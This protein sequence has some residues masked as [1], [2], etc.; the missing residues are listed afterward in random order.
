LAASFDETRNLPLDPK[1]TSM[2]QTRRLGFFPGLPALST[3]ALAKNDTRA[4]RPSKISPFL[5]F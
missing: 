3:E 5:W 1:N 4:T 2:H